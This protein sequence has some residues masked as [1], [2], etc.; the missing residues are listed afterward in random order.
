MIDSTTMHRR[1][2]RKTLRREQEKENEYMSYQQAMYDRDH[3]R[4]SEPTEY[5]TMEVDGLVVA[6]RF[7]NTS[8]QS[9]TVS[10]IEQTLLMTQNF[11]NLNESA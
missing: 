10:K 7:K 2:D 8:T 11:E 4:Y 1:S 3:P 5:I 6:L 9:D